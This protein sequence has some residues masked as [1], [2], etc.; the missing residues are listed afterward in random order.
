M[1]L[2]LRD[3]NFTISRIFS[4][5]C[6][7]SFFYLPSFAVFSSTHPLTHP[8]IHS[9]THP[10]THS[11][12]IFKLPFLMRHYIFLRLHFTLFL[13]TS[14]HG[15]YM[16]VEYGSERDSN[17]RPQGYKSRITR[18]TTKPCHCLCKE[19][20]KYIFCMRGMIFRE[21]IFCFQ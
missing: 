16:V 21:T 6:C 20:M 13:H 17:P 7:C 5:V 8:S 2:P 18:E 9:T 3:Y 15:T 11:A 14:I 12:I 1:I 19:F 10:P 4:V